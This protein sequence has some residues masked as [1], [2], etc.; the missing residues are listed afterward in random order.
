METFNTFVENCELTQHVY[1]V[2]SPDA[3]TDVLGSNWDI[4]LINHAGD[5]AQVNRPRDTFTVRFAERRLLSSFFMGGSKS[6]IH[7][8]Y[9]M[10]IVSVKDTGNKSD[11]LACGYTH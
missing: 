1:R 2:S 11:L 7:R 10:T 4:R 5:F 3:I 8:G 6:L 9:I